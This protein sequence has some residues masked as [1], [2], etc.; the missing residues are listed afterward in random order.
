MPSF[1]Q[2]YEEELRY[3]R[4]A[5]QE[6][7][8]AFPD[9]ARMLNLTTLEDRDPYVERLFEGF[10]FLTGRIRQKLDDDFP[11]FARNLLE[12]TD[13][14]FLRAIPSLCMA[15]FNFREGLLPKPAVLP[16]GTTLLNNPGRDKTVCRFR[17]TRDVRLMP[18]RLEEASAIHHAALGDGLRLDFRLDDAAELEPEDWRDLP[19]YLHGER[20]LAYFLHHFLTSRVS[21]VQLESGGKTVSLGG[22]ERIVPGGFG[23]DE[24]LLPSLDSSFEGSRFL[25]EF[26]AYDEKF[27]YADLDLRPLAGHKLGPT[28]AL[29]IHFSEPIPEGRRFGTQNFRLYAAPS[30]NLYPHKAEPVHLDHRHFEYTATPEANRRTETYEVQGVT[31]ID[32]ATGKRR[33]YLKFSDF[34]IP[35]VSGGG[36][37]GYFQA[38]QEQNAKGRWTTYLSLGRYSDRD[39]FE[40]EYLSVD[41]LALQGGVP[42]E[43]LQEGALCAAAPEFPAFAE[44]S[45]FTRP[46]PPVYPSKA[47]NTLWFVLSHF[48]LNFRSLCAKDVLKEVLSL[49]DWTHGAQ[50]KKMLEGLVSATARPRHFPVGNQLVAGTEVA[51]EVRDE[52]F[53][54][55][56]ELG[57]FGRV[58]LEFLSQYSSIN[59]R[60]SLRLI[61]IPSGRESA[62]EP[63]EGRCHP[64]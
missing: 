30:V 50:N 41:V 58:L 26:F 46:T 34:R 1:E 3:L 47:E 25:L 16:K 53:A 23:E 44:F 64:L 15:E 51:V 49:Y 39:A 60:V 35:A 6:F 52:A 7:A 18:L 4:E 22:Q 63:R 11:E 42:R 14:L 31:G 10:A 36:R 19:V 37:E 61:Q 21:Q 29:K 9:R 57:L 17:T 59:H 27:R 12:M 38:R 48:N 43:E 62:F 5:G 40:E 24:G 13:P 32:K 20:P 54:E 55:P 8:E 33:P 56:G 2:Y 28:F 45:N